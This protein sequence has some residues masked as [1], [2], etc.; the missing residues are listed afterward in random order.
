MNLPPC[1]LAAGRSWARRSGMAL[2]ILGTLLLI[3]VTTAHAQNIVVIPG[4]Q[5]M[6]AMVA[7][8]RALQ[9]EPALAALKFQILPQAL[10]GDKDLQ[11]LEAADVVIARHMIGAPTVRMAPTMQALIARGAKAYGA[12]ANQGVSAKLGLTE[13]TTL[14]AYMEA[15][16][17]ENLANMIRFLA[18][19]DFRLPV[20]A[21][22]PR[23]L[24]QA[25][26]WDPVSG[27]M[28]DRFEDYAEAYLARRGGTRSRPWVGL[29]INRG[30]AIGGSDESVKAIALA[31]EQRGLNVATVYG[32]PSPVPVERFLIDASG[33][34]RVAAVVALS[35]KLGNVPDKIGPVLARLDVPLV[36]AITLY[37]SSQKEWEDS[38]LGLD[39]NER[40]WQISGPEFAGIVA[41]T[42]VASKERRR[43]AATGL[44]YIAEAPIVE[45]VARVADRVRK[46][47][48]LRV[49]KPE[50]KRIAVIYYNSPPGNENVGASY[51]NVLPRSLWRILQRLD[52]EGYDAQGHPG[53]ETALFDRLREHGTN[54][55]SRSPG[56]LAQLVASGHMVLLPVAEYRNW[57]DKLPVRLREAMVKAWGEPEDFKLMVWR[58]AHGQKNFVFPAQRFGKLLFAPQPARGWGDVKKQYHDVTLPPHHQYLAFYLWLQKSFKAHAMVHVG[59][60]G[61]HEWLSGKEVGFTDADPGEL[62]V[63]AVPQVY[64]YSVDVVGEGLQAKRRGMATL[65][66]HM[67][68]P[69]DKAGLNPDLVALRGLL[70]DHGVALQKSES[71]A[72]ATRADI[73]ALARKMGILKDLGLADLKDTEG[74]EALQQYLEE[75]GQTQSPMGLHTFGVAPTEALRLAT[76]RA[77]VARQGELPSVE[78]DKRVDSFSQLMQDSA[79]AE[80]DAFVAALAGRYVLAGP[81]GDPLRNP[82]SLPTGRNFY[83]FDPTRLPTPGVYAQGEELAAALVRDY[84]KKHGVY[85]DRLLFN[86]WSNETMRHEGVLE[87]EILALLG[88]RP[89]WDG[90]GKVTDLQLVPR[91]QLGRP[92]V[93]VIITPSGLYRD[94]LPTLML[95]LDQAVSLVKDQ[96]EPDNVIRTNVARAQKALEE[97]GI[98]LEL[99]QRMA[100]VRLFTEPPGAYGTGLNNVIMASNTWDKESQVIDVYFKRVGH[101][102]G[103]GFWGDAPK[104]GVTDGADGADGAQLATDV[105]KMALKDVKAVL[106]SR[107]SNLYGTLDNDDVF[108]YLGGAAMAVRQVNGVTPDTLL[109][110]LADPTRA[111][112]E[113]LDQFVGREMRARYLNPVWIDA[114][115]KEGYAGT[116]FVRQVVDNLWG[117]QITVPEAVDGAKWQEMFETYVQD[118]HRLDIQQRFRA[119]KNLPAFQALVD[120]MLVAVN[121]GYWKAAPEVVQELN[122]VNRELIAQVGVACNRD[123]CSSEDVTR[124]AEQIDRLK[125]QTANGGFGLSVPTSAGMPK[126]AARA[127]TKAADAP[128]PAPPA[129]NLP[130]VVRG[131]E[132]REIQREQRLERLIWI[133]AGLILL[134]IL[135]GMAYQAWRTRREVRLP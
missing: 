81:G 71:A 129:A 78:R 124:I 67:T 105:F 26:L 40:S 132:L 100:A 34:A 116:R 85:P 54:I 42:V 58:D 37:K 66:S 83:G 56:A 17:A 75:I 32:F 130:A 91:A 108:Q 62:I 8:V 38:P 36:N 123:S 64:P 59:T 88:V 68:P 19:R 128:P 125:A 97:R 82:A 13:D 49:T 98:A 23:E 92:R 112:T 113:S 31:L 118:K 69:F 20:E 90:M 127:T 57:F 15:G 18:R 65:I 106:H 48:D 104:T 72:E 102:F 79:R 110:N 121:K 22:P 117:W 47:V 33:R 16:G 43:D 10:A 77:M 7:A 4:D 52:T 99:A 50:D 12:G 30:Q 94:A 133:Y 70:D 111:R 95:L 29:A 126:V 84:R 44:E 74:V 73:N 60:H 76:A 120:R 11:T 2:A 61:T 135:G 93:D 103:Q 96:P 115:L 80:L 89:V 35:M 87:A 5:A 53:S 41:P 25:A 14:N 27:Q 21:A 114:M 107:A 24:P 9:R 3:S 1:L 101:L 51:L 45:R 55:G 28:F 119:A 134:I 46:L 6:Q 131:Q 122:A 63:G 109:V 39:L 86:L